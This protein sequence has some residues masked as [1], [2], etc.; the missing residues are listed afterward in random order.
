MQHT[1]STVIK[2]HYEK[3]LRE[4]LLRTVALKTEKYESQRI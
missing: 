4:T 3:V 2:R 1:R